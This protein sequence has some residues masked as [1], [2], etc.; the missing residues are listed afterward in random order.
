ML[1]GAELIE[2]MSLGEQEEREEGR[3]IYQ[4]RAM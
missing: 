3:Q 2:H 1:M 4:G